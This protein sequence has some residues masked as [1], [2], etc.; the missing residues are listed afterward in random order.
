MS[1]FRFLS[2]TNRSVASQ[3]LASLLNIVITFFVSIFVARYIG[4]TFLGLISY[5]GAL[6]AIL[7]P[8]SSL[9]IRRAYPFLLCQDYQEKNLLETAFCIDLLTSLLFCFLLSIFAFYSNNLNISILIFFSI[10]TNFFNST[11]LFDSYLLSK[12][13]GSKI[14]LY[15]LILAGVN[16][17]LTFLFLFIKVKPI[18]FGL[19]P[20]IQAIFLAIFLYTCTFKKSLPRV[21][22]SFSYKVFTKLMTVGIPLMFVGFANLVCIK[23]DQLMLAWLKGPESV[24]Y[25]SVSARIV[26]SVY[27]IPTI[28]VN[29]YLPQLKISASGSE[30][31]DSIKKLYRLTWI[32]GVCSFI[33]FTFF[34]P[35]LVTIFYGF[36]FAVSSNLL[37]ILAPSAFVVSCGLASGA[38][39]TSKGFLKEQS[40]RSVFSAILNVSLNLL[41]IPHYGVYGAAVSTSISYSIGLFVPGLLK[42]STR[43]NYL[44]LLFPFRTPNFS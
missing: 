34:V 18:L 25:Y 36:E 38:W 13:Q 6:S 26:E 35:P 12:G 15:T 31:M 4:P 7:D 5:V 40:I 2:S 41:L 37:V 39:L 3:S 27:F 32:F 22:A 43:D 9:G 8:I 44:F 11:Q 21:L 10:V 17:V 28:L 16:L 42:T 1:I 30:I 14:A 19:V 23:S 20:L 24:G 33:A 29:T